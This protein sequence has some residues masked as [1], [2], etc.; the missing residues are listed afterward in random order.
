MVGDSVTNG[1]TSSSNAYRSQLNTR[2]VADG[3]T[4][5]G[6]V[7]T[8]DNQAASDATTRRHEG[9]NGD[10]AYD[11][12]QDGPTINRIGL[13]TSRVQNFLGPGKV[14][15]G[16]DIIMVNLGTNPESDSANGF[17]ANYKT[18]IEQMHTLEPQAIY[19]VNTIFSGGAD[20]SVAATNAT[21]ATVWG[22]LQAE[23][24]TLFQATTTL[25]AADLSDGTHPTAAGYV[26]LGNDIYPSLLSAL[27]SLP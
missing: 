14:A 24:I 1:Q 18:L 22:Q 17:A 25:T 2:A 13:P 11:K 19:V 3:W 7:G 4:N 12:R 5:L 8:R 23:G 16:V 27:N 6:F 10:N 9:I 21:L 20:G 26:K 15:N